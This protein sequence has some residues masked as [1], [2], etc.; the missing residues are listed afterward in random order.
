[1]KIHDRI[2]V[3]VDLFMGAL[4]SDDRFTGEEAVAI[5]RLLHDLL[6]TGSEATEGDP[7]PSDVEARI[8]AFDP[9]RFDLRAAAQDFISD[10]PMKKRRLL[11][12]VAA[13]VLADGELD[14]AEDDYLRAL[15]E[16]LGMRLD[17]Y[18][19]LLLDIEIEVLRQSFAEL[20]QAKPAKPRVAPPPIPKDAPAHR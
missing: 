14:L 13:M 18:Q 10:P 9:A 15:A 19:D 4:H 2:L 20:R 3:L 1:M 12:L 11:E 5:R 6:L 8:E 16:H 17:D 7:L